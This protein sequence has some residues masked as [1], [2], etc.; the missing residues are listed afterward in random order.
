[1][2][3]TP[4]DLK[5]A[6]K[7]ELRAAAYDGHFG[8]IRF[9]W[10]R[11]GSGLIRKGCESKDSLTPWLTRFWLKFEAQLERDLPVSRFFRVG[12]GPC[13]HQLPRVGRVDVG[14]RI[15]EQWVVEDIRERRGEGRPNP[16][17][18]RERFGQA[19]VVYIQARTK[20]TADFG[21]PQAAHIRRL[22]VQTQWVT[23]C[24]ARNFESSGVV[25]NECAGTWVLVIDR[26]VVPT[27]LAALA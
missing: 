26:G 13:P 8:A 16:L 6:L 9:G 2:D 1:M 24:T 4:G 19:E 3:N 23:I 22:R 15:V 10:G 25:V 27:L 5:D 20:D 11:R 12:I 18:H 21:I 14:V 17:A 7:K